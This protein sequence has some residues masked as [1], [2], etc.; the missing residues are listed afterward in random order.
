MNKILLSDQRRYMQ[1]DGWWTE[2]GEVPYD[3]L[4]NHSVVRVGSKIYTFGGVTG[5]STNIVASDFMAYDVDSG[6]WEI[7][8]PG[9]SMPDGRQSASLNY[10]DGRLLLMGGKNENEPSRMKSMWIYEP[11]W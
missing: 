6:T 3:H 5:S 4:Y 11:Q 1:D 10:H 7:V 2:V 8:N 9:S